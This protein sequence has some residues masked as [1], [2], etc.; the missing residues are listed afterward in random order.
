MLPT[1]ILVSESSHFSPTTSPLFLSRQPLSQ[2]GLAGQP[3]GGFPKIDGAGRE[4]S[5]P[6]PCLR[7]LAMGEVRVGSFNLLAHIFLA[8][9]WVGVV[10]LN[11]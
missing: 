11:S 2:P 7:Q 6:S 3:V 9:T 8:G 10:C 5:A 1:V 4:R